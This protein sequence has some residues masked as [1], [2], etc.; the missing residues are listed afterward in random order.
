MDSNGNEANTKAVIK[1]NRTYVPVRFIAE[2]MGENVEYRQPST[3]S[4]KNVTVYINSTNLPI[5]TSVEQE[6]K[7]VVVKSRITEIENMWQKLKPTFTEVKYNKIPKNTLP[8]EQGELTRET[9]NNALKITN[10]IRYITYLDSDV[11]LEDEFTVQAQLGAMTNSLNQRLSHDPTPPSGMDE[12]LYYTGRIGTATS[13]IGQGYSDIITSIVHGYMNDGDDSN[14]DSV[15]HRRWIISPKLKKVGF[16]Y[17]SSFTAMKVID[18]SKQINIS[19]PQE[20]YK[21]YDYVS[22]P[23]SVA[24]PVEYF[25]SYS[26]GFPWSVSLNHEKY[27]SNRMK[28]I[29]VEL[30]RVNDNKK[31]KFSN[32]KSDGYFNIDTQGFGDLRFTII[33]RPEE[34]PECKHGDKYKV[35]ISN[36]YTLDGSIEEISFE[37]TFFK[38]LKSL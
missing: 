36:I 29:K 16:G 12:D 5:D 3:S 23:A 24:M 15:G 20:P 18:T 33:F 14:I 9:L 13:N 31:W 19:D 1:N 7:D 11:V 28:D 26:Q 4:V 27:D 38:L 30:V 8:Y 21:E 17:F 10:F 32:N 25:N 35:V 2:A 34:I 6:T 37:T 22:W